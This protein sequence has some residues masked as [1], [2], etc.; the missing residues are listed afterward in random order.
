MCPLAQADGEYD[1]VVVIDNGAVVQ[2]KILPK[3]TDKKLWIER[4]DGHVV[5]I[6]RKRIALITKAGDPMIDSL[7]VEIIRKHAVPEIITEWKG[8]VRAGVYNSESEKVVAFAGGFGLLVQG[9]FQIATG[10]GWDH[11]PDRG[12]GFPIFIEMLGYIGKGT[13]LPYWCVNFGVTPFLAKSGTAGE[14]EFFL[15]WGL[16][17]VFPVKKGMGV[18][19][20][21]G[22]RTQSFVEEKISLLTLMVALHL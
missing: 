14:G 7:R 1:D 22:Y 11:Y 2:G 18:G 16:G 3:S 5:E 6:P 10:I 4:D 13:V 9:N 17:I 19:A 21:V 8:F 20:L 15:G 12:E